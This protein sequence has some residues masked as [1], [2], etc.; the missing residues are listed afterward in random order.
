MSIGVFL[1]LVGVD[2]IENG[3]RGTELEKLKYTRLSG[4]GAMVIPQP[5][6]G[7]ET[8]SGQQPESQGPLRFQRHMG[9]I[10]LFRDE[11]RGAGGKP[12]M[13]RTDPDR[14]V[15]GADGVEAGDRRS[16]IGANRR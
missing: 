7:I 11:Q 16:E 6:R 8:R 5:P 2:S 14:G 12:Q 10:C 3:I 9:R 4:N 1:L 13:S 15:A